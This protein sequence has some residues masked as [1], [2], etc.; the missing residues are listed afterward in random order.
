[1]KKYIL[2]LLL[3]PLLSNAQDSLKVKT[4]IQLG[5]NLSGGNNAS[6]GGNLKASLS[7]DK[8]DWETIVAPNLA[9]NFTPN[10]EDSKAKPILTQRDLYNSLTVTHRFTKRMKLIGFS[11]VEN[12]YLRQIDLRW[13]GGVGPGY[14]ILTDK[15]EFNISEVILGEGLNSNKLSVSNYFVLRASTRLKIAYK[16]KFGTLSSLTLFQPAIYAKNAAEPNFL[17]W[18]TSNK[19]E[20]NVDKNM[21][22]GFSYDASY[23]AYPNSKDSSILPFNWNTSLFL[24]YKFNK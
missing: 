12:S 22:T 11:E 24:A 8:G 19:I 21:S 13:N 9:I 16:M 15:F 18:R 20:F 1:M 10:T 6:Y 14:K 7:L 5:L 4:D 23:E 2:L 17:I 3:L